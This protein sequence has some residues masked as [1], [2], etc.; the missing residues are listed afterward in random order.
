M[1]APDIIVID[2]RAYSWRRVCDIRRQQL[3]ARKAGRPEQSALFELREDCRPVCERR[4]AGR[5]IE[6]TLLAWLGERAESVGS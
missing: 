1:K 3:D 2:G 6:P 4:A 5:Y